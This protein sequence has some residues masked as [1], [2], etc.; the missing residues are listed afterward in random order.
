LTNSTK[1]E[2]M[3]TMDTREKMET[4]AY[5]LDFKIY[6]LLLDEP[7]FARLSRKLD[8]TPL[9]SIPTAGIMYNKTSRNFEIVYNPKFMAGLAKDSWQA[10]VIKHELYHASLGHCTTRTLSD[11]VGDNHQLA[12]IAM[13][14]AIDSL[15]GMLDTARELKWTG[16]DGQVCHPLVPG[17]QPYEQIRSLEQSADWYANQLMKIQPPDEN[18]G[19]GCQEEGGKG[20]GQPGKGEG[21]PGKGEGQGGSVGKQ[22]DTHEGFGSGD[23]LTEDERM[24]REIAERRIADAVAEAAQECD[25][26]DGETQA[27]GWG[28][29]SHRIRKKIKK[30]A[31]S[32]K[33]KLDPK[34][35]LNSFVRASVNAEK[36]TSV[37]KRNR[38]LP[39][40]KFGRRTDRRAKIAI[41][42]DMS[43]SV[44]DALLNRVFTWLNS[45][46]KFSEFTVIPF[47]HQVFEEKIY[48]WKKG[49]NKKRERVLCGG[50]CFTAP[51]KYVNKRNFDGHIIITDMMAPK[52]IRS[53]CQ[54]MWITDQRG[55]NGTYFKPVGE[56]VLVL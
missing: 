34:A 24:E 33:S 12:N 18:E 38:R 35:V 21:Q 56:R 23:E 25:V 11:I 31:N 14:L 3:A 8:K 47:D 32:N 19:G 54:R 10:W 52:P 45:L 44:G 36:K 7:F 55:A 43:G 6:K 29:V 22:H 48:V 2:K 42:I 46:A 28:T 13:D 53:N 30:F 37:T 4:K 49:E 5:D 39:G 1:F 26:G 27:A 15:P 51:T 9:N 40:K 16:A 50:T 17:R 41:S 20:E